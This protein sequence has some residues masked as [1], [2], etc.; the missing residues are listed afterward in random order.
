LPQ[1]SRSRPTNKPSAR[2]SGSRSRVG[3]R[4]STGGTT[5]SRGKG[6]TQLETAIGQLEAF[7]FGIPEVRPFGRATDEREIAVTPEPQVRSIQAT[8]PLASVQS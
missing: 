7:L 2:A 6:R 5:A 8:L 3:R 4:A 1:R